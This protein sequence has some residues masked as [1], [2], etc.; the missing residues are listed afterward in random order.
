MDVG[1]F[2]VAIA[3]FVVG[4]QPTRPV[5]ARVATSV[6][7]RFMADDLTLKVDG[8]AISGWMDVRVTRRCEACPNDFQVGLTERFPGQADA[9]SIAAGAPFTLLIGSDPVMT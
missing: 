7:A 3:V 2:A 1:A 9:V 8:S 6:R 5:S 4:L